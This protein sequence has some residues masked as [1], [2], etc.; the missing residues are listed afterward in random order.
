[1]TESPHSNQGHEP[2]VQAFSVRYGLHPLVALMMF[3]LDYMLF[4]TLE[5]PSMGLLAVLS[6]FIG[7]AAVIPC[8]LIQ[9]YSYHDSW[10]AAVGK[11]MAVGLLTAVPSPLPSFIT[12]AWGVMGAVGMFQR[13]RLRNAPVVEQDDNHGVN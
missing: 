4:T 13:N 7:F 2:D 10:G 1:M 9:K 12:G 8:A 5:L 6:F 3:G 11:A